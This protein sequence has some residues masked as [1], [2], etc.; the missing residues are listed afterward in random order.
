MLKI[1][2]GHKNKLGYPVIGNFEMH[3]SFWTDIVEQVQ[4]I[5]NVFNLFLFHLDLLL[6]LR[7]YGSVLPR[8]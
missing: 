6:Q 5:F 1:T 4:V 3:A 8:T 2:L 7:K